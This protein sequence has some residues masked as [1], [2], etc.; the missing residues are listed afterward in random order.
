MRSSTFVTKIRWKESHVHSKCI[1]SEN[2]K[3]REEKREKG[4]EEG[5]GNMRSLQFLRKTRSNEDERVMKHNKITY[6]MRAEQNTRR[7]RCS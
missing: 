1:V 4:T 2:W 3:Q 6:L 5:K 7:R